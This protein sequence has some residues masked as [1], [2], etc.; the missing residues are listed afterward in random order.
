MGATDASAERT[1]DFLLGV[2]D[3]TEC[4]GSGAEGE[5]EEVLQFPRQFGEDGVYDA[6]SE[7][8]EY[9]KVGDDESLV[10]GGVWLNTFDIDI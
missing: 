3:E 5:C 4:V 2:R 10:L 6:H 7:E 9:K 1:G 8:C